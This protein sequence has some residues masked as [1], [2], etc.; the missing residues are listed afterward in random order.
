MSLS[1]VVSAPIT[2]AASGDNIVIAA[3]AGKAFRIRKLWLV[4]T[5]DSNLTFKDGA[6][7]SLS[8]IISMLGN[9][10][11]FFPTDLAIPHF[12]TTTGNAFIINSSVAVQVSGMVYYEV[13]NV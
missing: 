11:F 1:Q 5:G 12:I 9:G 2:F 10:S 8:G 4:L 6:S 3:V 7:A 13:T